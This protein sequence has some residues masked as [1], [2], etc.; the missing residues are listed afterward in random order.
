MWMDVFMQ[1]NNPTKP[2]IFN[3]LY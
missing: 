1:H 2:P 3:S